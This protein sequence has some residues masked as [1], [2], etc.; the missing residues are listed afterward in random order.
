MN[1]L[2]ALQ[3]SQQCLN[4]IGQLG[5]EVE[6]STDFEL[7]QKEM[8]K[9]GK[10]EFSPMLMAQANDF[11]SANCFWMFLKRDGRIIG[12]A[13]AKYDDLERETVASYWER[14]L[15]RHYPVPGAQTVF[16]RA[17]SAACQLRGRMVYMG[18]L[19]IQKEERG[20]PHLIR[21]YTHLLFVT[22]RM[23]WPDV[24]WIYVFLRSQEVFRGR[25][26][27]YGFTD[28]VPGVL[29]WEDS[30]NYRSVSDQLASISAERLAHI[31][32]H[33]ATEP[34][35]LMRFIVDGKG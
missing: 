3:F 16:V 32:T 24:D 30:I 19:F 18:D 17:E 22:V 8:N 23:K 31:V 29:A 33:Y 12:G 9:L 5:Y 2:H 6:I 15:K 34:G 35:E 10:H 28:C 25:V 27:L 21:Y 7:A 11:T 13:C 14:T 20:S 4:G 1:I 26:A